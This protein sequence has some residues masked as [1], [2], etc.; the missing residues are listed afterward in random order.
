M[1][2]AEWNWAISRVWTTLNAAINIISNDWPTGHFICFI[3]CWQHSSASMEL[4]AIDK[5]MIKIEWNRYLLSLF[6]INFIYVPT[7]EIENIFNDFVEAFRTSLYR[8]PKFHIRT[9]ETLVIFKFSSFLY[10]LI[11]ISYLLVCF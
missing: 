11:L 5:L 10:K 7:K 1:W 9:A 6:V 2:A 8:S 3:Y 4:L